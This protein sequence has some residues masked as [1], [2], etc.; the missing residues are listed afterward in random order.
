MGAC[1]GG[2][3]ESKSMDTKGKGKGGKGGKGGAGG[4]GGKGGAGKTGGKKAGGAKAK[5]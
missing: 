5:E 2:E 4:K 1:C 3:E